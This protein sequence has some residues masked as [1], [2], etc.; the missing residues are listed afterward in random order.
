MCG[1]IAIYLHNEEKNMDEITNAYNILANRGPDSGTWLVEQDKIIG[2]RRLAIV[3]TSEKGTQPFNVNGDKL[4]CN[5][6][7]FN[8]K[9]LISKYDL[10]CESKSDCECIIHL[11]HKIG[12]EKMIKELI[13]DFA[14]VIFTEN[15]VLFGRDRIG[16]RPLFYGFTKEGNFA[17]GSYARVLTGYCDNVT[18]VNP[19]WAE[20]DYKTKDLTFFH[21]DQPEPRTLVLD[22]YKKIK[23]IL[24]TAVKD[25]LMGERPI[26][27]LLSGGLDSSLVTSILCKLIG[28]EN[29]RTYSIGMVGSEDLRH[30]QIVANYLGTKHTEV[31][32][33]QK[34]DLMLFQ[35]LFVIWNHMI[36]QQS[37][38]V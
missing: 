33:H 32:L 19:G 25:R 7:I 21:Y 30:A 13:G 38:Q 16:V 22:I 37:E 29:V 18:Q 9:D 14:I 17:L 12:F 1:I 36:L 28:H 27:C 8:H 24:T 31:I 6:E 26:G 3:D 23:N 34:K 35:V 10:S 11:Y 4:L 2:F 5:G 20:Y 15:K